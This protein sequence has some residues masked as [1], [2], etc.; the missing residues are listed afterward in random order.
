MKVWWK[1]KDELIEIQRETSQLPFGSFF[2]TGPI[3][4]RTVFCID[5]GNFVCK[6]MMKFNL[7]HIYMIFGE[8]QR[9][10]ACLFS[11]KYPR[12]F[13]PV[14]GSYATLSSLSPRILWVR[15]SFFKDI[16]FWFFV[17]L[18]AEHLEFSVP[19]RKSYNLPFNF[20]II[21]VPRPIMVVEL[22]KHYWSWNKNDE[23]VE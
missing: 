6:Y 23:E 17:V 19:S 18:T 14:L 7:P 1:L 21:L 2:L 10:Q 13:Q 4:G 16:F 8:C 22:C 3:W 20:L 9:K 12:T 15:S 11:L 5:I